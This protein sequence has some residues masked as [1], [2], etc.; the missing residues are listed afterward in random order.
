MLH[1]KPPGVYPGSRY[2]SGLNLGIVARGSA[3]QPSA[4]SQPQQAQQTNRWGPPGQ[5]GP[6]GPGAS[7]TEEWERQQEWEEQQRRNRR[8]EAEARAMELANESSEREGTRTPAPRWWGSQYD[9]YRYGGGGGRGGGGG[10]GGGGGRTEVETTTSP[11]DTSQLSSILASLPQPMS[12]ASYQAGAAPE[13]RVLADR[14]ESNRTRLARAKDLIGEYGEGAQRS[15][16]EQMSL[17]GRTGSSWEGR[18]MGGL[19]AALLG[20]Q[21]EAVRDVAAQD[22]AAEEEV[23]RYNADATNRYREVEGGR[24]Q[25][26]TQN[27]RARRQASL[28]DRIRLA[29]QLSGQG[30]RTTTTTSRSY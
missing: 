22:L 12:M 27:E 1:V 18:A 15:V 17:L 16:R 11:Y 24:R 7:R 29:A 5:W 20:E 3:G 23:G 4:P 8:S 10:G 6:Q 19:S 14:T 2:S 26:W 13:M 9:P 28:T 21:G 30:G 25:S